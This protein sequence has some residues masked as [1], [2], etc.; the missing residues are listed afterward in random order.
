LAALGISIYGIIAYVINFVILI[1][2]LRMFLYAPIKNMLAQ[3][4]QHIAD[5]LAAADKAAQEAA[6]QRQEF[7]KSLAQ[8]KQSSQE[9]AKKVAAATEKNASG[10]FGCCSKRSRRYKSQSPRRSRARTSASCI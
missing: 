3:R 5:G 9:E 8:A 1:V 6:Q 10:Y 7:E 4:Q 2:L